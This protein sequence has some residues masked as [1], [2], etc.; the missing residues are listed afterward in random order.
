MG[1]GMPEVLL[2]A[3]DFP[4][5]A[6]V[7]AGLRSANFARHLPEFGWQPTVVAL[8]QGQ[9]ASDKVVRLPSMT[10]WHRPYEMTPYGWAFGLGRHLR[11]RAGHRYDLVYVS[12]PPYP[13][14]LSAM[15]YAA[16]H[17]LP[18]VVDFR[19]AWALDPYQEGSRL[20]RVLYRYLFPSLERRL[21]ANTD[22]LI[23]N[24]PSA[25][26][27][28]QAHYPAVADRMLYLPNGYDEAA[29]R[30]VDADRIGDSDVL[31]LL[32]AGRFGIGA[33]SPS[34][35]I[36]GLRI[37]QSRGCRV[38]LDILGNQ[39]AAIRAEI[40]A[41]GMGDLVRLLG[42]VDYTQAVRNMASA[43]VL[44]LIQAPSSSTVQAVAGKTFDYI[45]SGRPILVVAPAGDNLDLIR[46]HAGR[47]EHAEDTPEAIAAGIVS[48]YKAWNCGKLDGSQSPDPGFTSRFE[49]RALTAALA[50]QFDRLTGRER[51]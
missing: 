10:P 23:L 46:A 26:A 25:L 14:A 47:Y 4:P 5:S 43:D 9:V 16:S 7:G 42:E 38:R 19:D 40:T 44:V 33:R 49:R 31:T 24:T 12:C 35:L 48:L 8:D 30:D 37:A 50:G 22:L 6:G 20:K 13:Q 51:D 2:I 1:S 32:Y 3:Y 45:R 21:L 39:G 15:S 41:E 28:Y 18:L 11:G 36:A 34:N 27:A 17:S 29:F